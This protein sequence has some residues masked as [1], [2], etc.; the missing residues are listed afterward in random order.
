MPLQELDHRIDQIGKKYGEDEDQNDMPS[1]VHGCTHPGNQ[2]NG[3]QDIDGTAIRE[4]HLFLSA[5]VL[6]IDFKLTA[7]LSSYRIEQGTV[8][9]RSDVVLDWKDE[10]HDF[11]W[12][13]PRPPLGLLL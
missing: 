5:R 10:T 4:G 11:T 3:Q 12:A 8:I 13:C 6:K 9:W 2:E 1:T 7:K